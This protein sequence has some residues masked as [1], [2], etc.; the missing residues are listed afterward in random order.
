MAALPWLGP[1]SVNCATL[2]LLRGPVAETQRT[3][4]KL[5]PGGRANERE[6]SLTRLFVF[7]CVSHVISKEIPWQERKERERGGSC[8][9]GAFSCRSP[10]LSCGAVL[11]ETR[12]Q[13]GDIGRRDNALS[14]LHR[15][16]S[17]ELCHP[18]RRNALVTEPWCTGASVREA[19]DHS[20]E[21][22]HAI[23]APLC[24][25]YA[26][27]SGT[28]FSTATD[29]LRTVAD[30]SVSLAAAAPISRGGLIENKRQGRGDR[31]TVPVVKLPRCRPVAR[32]STAPVVRAT[33]S[34]ARMT[35]IPRTPQNPG[36][37]QPRRPADLAT[38]LLQRY[39]AA[40]RARAQRRPF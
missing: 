29:S 32:E 34:P 25:S 37:G 20:S 33:A 21:D 2:G 3:P 15:A 39:L 11:R 19:S 9:L 17:R 27:L 36:D 22:M 14:R 4:K 6:R 16:A 28:S 31:K 7:A 40:G 38:R 23:L 13:L 35:T 1:D 12:Q 8:L 18:R 24:A 30:L 5:R 26:R 10:K